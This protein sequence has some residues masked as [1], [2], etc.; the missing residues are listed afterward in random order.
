MYMFG[1]FCF[2]F[3]ANFLLPSRNHHLH[4]VDVRVWLPLHYV[5]LRSLHGTTAS[6]V[7]TT[8]SAS[9][10]FFSFLSEPRPFLV[11]VE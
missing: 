8:C 7:W 1:P 10:L 6:L 9:L 4:L 2:G 5:G 11:G 3:L